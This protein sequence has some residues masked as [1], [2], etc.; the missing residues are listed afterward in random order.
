MKPVGGRGKKAVGYKSTHVRI[1]DAIKDRVE[2]LKEQY[3]SGHLDFVDELTAENN[4]LANEYRKLLTGNA[5][6]TNFDKHLLTSL[7]EDLVAL[8]LENK[9]LR[10]ELERVKSSKQDLLDTVCK[11]QLD[12]FKASIK[13][14]VEK[15]LALIDDD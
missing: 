6:D 8:Q 9:Q 2:K 12:T 13:Q 1:P 3:F 15:I 10:L 7:K 14:E 5:Q 11:S 4:K